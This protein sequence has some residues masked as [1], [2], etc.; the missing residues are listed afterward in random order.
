MALSN[1][2]GSVTLISG[3]AQANGGDFALMEA[4][5]IQTQED[6][7]RLDTELNSIQTNITNLKTDIGNIIEATS[8]EIQALF[9]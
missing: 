1:Y 3:I 4:S 8:A 6:G 7:T 5:A 9:N 2:K